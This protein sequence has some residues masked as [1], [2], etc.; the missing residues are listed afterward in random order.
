MFPGN[1]FYGIRE[2]INKY[3]GRNTHD[4]I[5]F[6]I[7][8]GIN[9]DSRPLKFYQKQPLKIWTNNLREAKIYSEYKYGT[10]PLGAPFLYHLENIGIKPFSHSNRLKLGS[11]ILVLPS[12]STNRVAAK[13]DHEE[14]IDNIISLF[15][16][17]GLNNITVQ[18]YGL[19]YSAAKLYKRKGLKTVTSGHYY[20]RNFIS[21]FT[22]TAVDNAIVAANY[23]TSG[24]FY[25]AS[26]GMKIVKLEVPCGF[27]GHDRNSHDYS[28]ACELATDYWQGLT[29]IDYMDYAAEKTG[30][31]H[32][33]SRTALH[34]LIEEE[35]NLLKGDRARF[36][37]VIGYAVLHNIIDNRIKIP[38]NLRYAYQL[39][40]GESDKN[41]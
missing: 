13:Q 36:I 15:G 4:R 18:L 8:H 14:L 37:K 7:F 2:I 24:L 17:R 23:T 19:D 3:C 10:K 29:G 12:H 40:I 39:R 31:Q 27:W 26:L 41:A 16:S 33:L 21:Q 5:P 9:Q 35:L 28:A 25:C 30:L 34:S 22:K 6:N 1:V 11:G 32:I 20:T 38:L